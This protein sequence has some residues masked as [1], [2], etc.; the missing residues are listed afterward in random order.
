[1]FVSLKQ[2]NEKNSWKNT[3]EFLESKLFRHPNIL[4]LCGSQSKICYV[5]LFSPIWNMNF[6]KFFSPRFSECVLQMFKCVT[7]KKT[8]QFDDSLWHFINMMMNISFIHH[9]MIYTWE[10]KLHP[11]TGL[12]HVFVFSIIIINTVLCSK[13]CWEKKYTGISSRFSFDQIIITR[14]ILKIN[15]KHIKIHFVFFLAVKKNHS[16][17]HRIFNQNIQPQT[18]DV[19]VSLYH[20][21]HLR[22]REKR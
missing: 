16:N 10:K 8:I 21:Q 18:T 13:G 4:F 1:M 11:F 9:Q 5:F 15:I 14:F 2:T 6:L 12:G 22:R 7:K 19:C 20:Q 17:T 3:H